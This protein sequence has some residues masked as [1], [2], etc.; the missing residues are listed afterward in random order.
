MTSESHTMNLHSS[1]RCLTVCVLPLTFLFACA[2][3]PKEAASR[4]PSATNLIHSPLGR[5]KAQ[6]T[7]GRRLHRS[8][9]KSPGAPLAPGTAPVKGANSEGV[10]L[11]G[12]PAELEGAPT[13][14]EGDPVKLEGR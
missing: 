12:H 8:G 4:P 5:P 6:A 14:L 2:R 1:I 3:P 9:G 11:E 10:R 13:K 7:P